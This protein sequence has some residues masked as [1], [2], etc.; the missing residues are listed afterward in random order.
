MQKNRCFQFT[1]TLSRF[2][3]GSVARG[4][5]AAGDDDPIPEKFQQEHNAYIQALHTAGVEPIVLPKLEQFP[6]S[7]FVED[8]ALCFDSQVVLLRPGAE[9]RFGEAEALAPHLI[10]LFGSVM[11][12]EGEGRVDGGDILLTDSVALIG[13]SERT[14]RDG[15]NALKPILET[16]GYTIRVVNTPSGVLHFKSDCGLLDDKTIF[17]TK[18]LASSDC[19]AEF[20]VIEAPDGEEAAANL[21]RVNDFVILRAGFPKTKLLL[22]QRGYQ[23]LTVDTEEAAKIDGGL[24]C[25]SLRFSL[26]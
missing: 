13:L 19:F 15:V 24:S 8:A 17:S 16:H 4:I 10:D 6:D 2:P 7:V 1:H 26:S 25:L 9:S 23:I 20:E 14:D 3:G 12:L 18:I 21:I 22:E 11:A 5:R